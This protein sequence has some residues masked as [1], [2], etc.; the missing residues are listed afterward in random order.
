MRTRLIAA[1][2]ASAFVATPATAAADDATGPFAPYEDLLQVLAS[3]TWHLRDDLYRFP[4]P[5]D[6]T[7]YD[8]FKLSL[9]RLEAWEKRFPSRL[10]DVTAIARAEALERLGEY[11]R[12]ASLYDEIAASDSPLAAHAREQAVYARAFADAASLPEHDPQLERRLQLLRAKLDAWGALVARAAG[13]PRHSLALI[14][15]ERLEEQAARLVVAYRHVLADGDAAAER[16]LRFLIEKH[17][18]SKRLAAHVLALGDL[19]AAQLREYVEAH[20]RPLDF[21][22]KE[23]TRR[24]DRAL[25][26]YQKVANWDGI[27]EK[28]EAEARFAATEAYRDATLERFK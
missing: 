10:P 9:G 27:P 1:L 6:P 16:S 8:V 25:D 24:C 13:T 17:A 2:L 7:G 12:A 21:D 20:D 4:A 3:L 18:E 28:P 26:A 19:Y 11:G 5:K 22:V 14:E 23:F 15:E